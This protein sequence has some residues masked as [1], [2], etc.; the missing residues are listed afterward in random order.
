MR[1]QNRTVNLEPRSDAVGKILTF[2][3]ER[4]YQPLERLPSE[5]EFAEKFGTSRGAVREALAA[6]EAMR[7]VERRPNSGIYLR[8]SD[9]S[10][11]EALVL[12][13]ESGL[14]F[15]AREIDDAFEVRRILEVQAVRLACD[16]RTPDDIRA[17][18]AILKNTR[19][20]LDRDETIE[21][22][23]E[24]FHLAILS[25]TK[26]D[27]LLRVVKSS[28][29]MSRQRRHVYFANQGRGLRSFKDHCRILE[30]IENRRVD[31]ADQSMSEHLSQAT[32][33]WQELLGEPELPGKR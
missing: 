20:R 23:D 9:E 26:N 28:Y 29:E 13:A 31:Q 6:L 2:I 10:S 33:T 8:N 12:H 32:E 11:I 24:A 17:F 19:E 15:Q 25:A 30:A 4:R 7:V 18:H 3:R 21:D 16:R 22:E 14:P 5:R 27:I 1:G